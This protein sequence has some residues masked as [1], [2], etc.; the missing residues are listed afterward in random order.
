[1]ATEA[2]IPRSVTINS[3]CG[4]VESQSWSDPRLCAFSEFGILPT[5]THPTVLGGHTGQLPERHTADRRP[6]CVIAL[7]EAFRR[8]C[9]SHTPWPIRRLMGRK[10]IGWLAASR[11]PRGIAQ[12]RRVRFLPV[13]KRAPIGV[14][15]VYPRECWYVHRQTMIVVLPPHRESE[16]EA[17]GRA[18]RR[19]PE[20]R[21]QNPLP[22]WIQPSAVARSRPRLRAGPDGL[23][24]G[25]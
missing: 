6:R 12:Q 16:L 23:F 19:L 20:G 13:V 1:M 4:F 22:E 14:Q 15:R 3:P 2:P 10:R 11:N 5:S 17:V 8:E 18:E 7:D 25:W 24:V 9:R 21:R